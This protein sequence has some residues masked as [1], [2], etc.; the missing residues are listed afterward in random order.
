MPPTPRLGSLTEWAPTLPDMTREGEVVWVA[1]AVALAGAGGALIAAA[2]FA[3]TMISAA[4]AAVILALSRFGRLGG[5]WIPV[6]IAAAATLLPLVAIREA[7]AD[8]YVIVVVASWAVLMVLA[9]PW[10]GVPGGLVVGTLLLALAA[11]LSGFAAGG[12][13]PFPAA[14]RFLTYTLCIAILAN[15]TGEQ[16]RRTAQATVLIIAVLSGSVFATKLGILSLPQIEDRES[17]GVRIG[18]LVGHP[19]FAAY[20]MGIAMLY[21]LAQE[22]MR[23]HF[24]YPLIASFTGAILITGSRSA[25]AFLVLGALVL[26]ARWWRH[27]VVVIVIAAALY[28][29]Y[30]DVIAQRVDSL[31]SSGG[32]Q[33]QNSSGWRLQHWNYVFDQLE[34][35]SLTG[36]GWGRAQTLLPGQLAVHNGYLQVWFELGLLGLAALLLFAF[37]LWR[38]ARARG[39]GAMV[40]VGYVFAT[41]AGDM[42]LLYPPIAYVLLILVFGTQSSTQTCTDSAK[43]DQPEAKSRPPDTDNGA[44]MEPLAGTRDHVRLLGHR[45]SH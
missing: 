42:V 25:L 4:A 21:V 24:R 45:N 34:P 31:T 1:V 19:N 37:A 3:A 40:L 5:G 43:G 33:G 32:I 20:L 44:W 26:L 6:L 15:L 11:L 27:S 39:L 2:P 8:N 35:F 36:V 23:G 10:R 29:F 9:S 38:L 30:G 13:S 17:A 22:D 28:R 16:R 7:P 18:G 12:D 41:N 14:V